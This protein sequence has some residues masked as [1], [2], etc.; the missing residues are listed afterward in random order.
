MVCE[1][2]EYLSLK[3]KQ[4]VKLK[5][6][7]IKTLKSEFLSKLTNMFIKSSSR[8]GQLLPECSAELIIVHLWLTLA[9]TPESRHL[10][11]VL[12]DKLAVVALPR[13][14][15]VVLLFP[16][17]FENEVPELDLPGAWA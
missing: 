5:P 1:I 13:D 4:L 15:I 12:D 7:H 10:I 11:R 3:T 8:F 2:V 9:G 16:Q 17:Q 14:D 6:K